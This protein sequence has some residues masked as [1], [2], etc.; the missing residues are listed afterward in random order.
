MSPPSLADFIIVTSNQTKI[1]EYGRFAG[2]GLRIQEGE[3]LA[4]V[5]GSPDE[6]LIYKALAAGE[7]RMVEDA[8]LVIDGEPVVDTKYRVSALRRGEC[9]VG[10]PVIWQVRLG[11]LLNGTVYGYLGET[12]GTICEMVTPG[13][14][15]D[16]VILVNG[17]GKSLAQLELEGE[18][19][20]FSARRLAM[21]AVVEKAPYLH[22]QASSISPWQGA[23]QGE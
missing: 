10:T 18:K 16:P 2:A 11:V 4:E 9:A 13:Y 1:R 22:V 23:Y 8:I 15:V 20:T 14:G 21:K 5:M 19:D 3:D 6:V 12:P 17:V 7:G